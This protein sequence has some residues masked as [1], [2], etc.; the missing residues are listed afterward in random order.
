MLWR[1]LFC[2]V[3]VSWCD[4]V[5]LVLLFMI[6]SIHRKD[7]L[8]HEHEQEQVQHHHRVGFSFRGEMIL[9]TLCKCVMLAACL[10]SHC[11]V[12]VCGSKMW[13]IRCQVCAVASKPQA[14]WARQRVGYNNYTY[15]TTNRSL[16]PLSTY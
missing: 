2:R 3:C 13:P 1:V 16:P 12:M 4:F 15:H 11:N 5:L 9:L 8:N 7:V 10:H 14:K 6:M